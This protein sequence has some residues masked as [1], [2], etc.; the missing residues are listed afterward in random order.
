[1]LRELEVILINSCSDQLRIKER[2]SARATACRLGS[3]WVVQVAFAW[4][5]DRTTVMVDWDDRD[6]EGVDGL[7][8]RKGWTKWLVVQV[9][10]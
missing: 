8:G 4:T 10:L 9:Y 2:V 6:R 1:M 5:A 7:D 3:I